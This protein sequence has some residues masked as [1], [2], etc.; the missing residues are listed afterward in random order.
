MED[1][2]SEEEG[3]KTTETLEASKLKPK[4]VSTEDLK[5]WLEDREVKLKDHLYE[6]TFKVLT[7]NNLLTYVLL[8]AHLDATS[9]QWIAFVS[10]RKIQQR[11]R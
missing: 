2:I 8:T 7:D 11:C 6:Q 1:N 10:T 5:K 9:R 3:K 4:C